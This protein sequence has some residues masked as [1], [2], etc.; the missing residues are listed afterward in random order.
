MVEWVSRELRGAI[1]GEVSA[2]NDSDADTILNKTR[3]GSADGDLGAPCG[4]RSNDAAAEKF[5]QR[6]VHDKEKKAA[7]PAEK[8]RPR[9]EGADSRTDQRDSTG[10]GERWLVCRHA[11][12]QVGRAYGERAKGFPGDE[13]I[14]RDREAG[15]AKPAEAR[16]GIGDRRGGGS[17][18]FRCHGGH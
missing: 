7:G 17:D 8:A 1:P 6:F 9:A 13:R 16:P 2:K 14:A 18:T 3:S 12:R 4:E 15:C 5:E 11:H 10:A